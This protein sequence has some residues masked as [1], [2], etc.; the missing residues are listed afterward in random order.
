MMNCSRINKNG[1]QIAT[2]LEHNQRTSINKNC[3]GE[4]SNY[5]KALFFDTIMSVFRTQINFTSEG[6]L[7]LALSLNRYSD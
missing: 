7:T 3:L 6:V 5:D 2:L 1:W 4:Q